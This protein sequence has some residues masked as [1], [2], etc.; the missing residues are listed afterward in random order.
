MKRTDVAA[1]AFCAIVVSC[2][3]SGPKVVDELTVPGT[4][5]AFTF[6]IGQVDQG[7][8]YLADRTNKAL[9]VYDAQTGQLIAQIQ[10]GFAGQTGANNDTSGPDGV[11]AIPGTNTVYVGDVSSVKVVDV[12]TKTVVKN[13][14]LTP[15]G[16]PKP[17]GLRADEGCYDKDDNL[18]M[19]SHPADSPPFASFIST[20]TQ[21]LVTQISFTGSAG[22]EACAYDPATKSFYVNNDGTP[23]NPNGEVDVIT[24]ASVVA[25]APVVAKMYP[26]GDCGPTGLD[27]GPGNEMVVGCDPSGAAGG[28]PAGTPIVTLILDRT[29]G[30]KLASVPIGGADQVAYDPVSN[31]YFVAARRW[32]TGGVLVPAP[33]GGSLAVVPSLGIIDAGSRTLVMRLDAGNNAHSV[34]VDG[35]AHRVFV[36]HQPQSSNALFPAAGITVYSTR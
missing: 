5:T 6:D 26:L 16:S 36:P 4:S 27:L 7:R 19:F 25:H 22:L 34:A 13:I 17:S 3:S 18:M 31:R 32:Q 14:A 11:N 15:P 28:A 10:G 2:T 12:G 24:A 23:A 20:T 1:A 33:A 35:A 9:D 21:T 8:Y 29:N 30:N